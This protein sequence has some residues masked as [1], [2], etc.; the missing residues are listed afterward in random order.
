MSPIRRAALRALSCVFAAATT[1]TIAPTITLADAAPLALSYEIF[2][3]SVPH[4]DLAACPEGLEVAGVA[5]DDLFCRATVHEDGFHV[6]VFT[7][8]GDSPAIAFR[9]YPVEGVETLLK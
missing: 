1:L 8:S 6:F 2:E 5:A 3:A 4:I 9:S 7:Y